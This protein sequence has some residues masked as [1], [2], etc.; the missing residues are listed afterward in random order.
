MPA[1]N[2]TALSNIE[3]LPDLFIYANNSTAVSGQGMLFGLI[4][5]ALFFIMLFVL[6]RWEFYKELLS[7]SFAMFILTVILSF[8][9]LV[10][11]IFPLTFLIIMAFTGLYAWMNER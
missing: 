2:I 4:S 11:F 1:Y 5:V 7:S 3:T 6:K 8:A 9:Q 10:N